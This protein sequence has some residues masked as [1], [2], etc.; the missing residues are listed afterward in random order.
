MAA[1]VS[2]LNAKMAI[3]QKTFTISNVPAGQYYENADLDVSVPGYTAMGIVGYNYTHSQ[4]FCFGI[5]VYVGTDKMYL[6]LKTIN[7][8]AIEGEFTVYAQIL[9]FKK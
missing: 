7:S 6:G 3:F 2:S 1:E 4:V 9:Y 5:R 8:A